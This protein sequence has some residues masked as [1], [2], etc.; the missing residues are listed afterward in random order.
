MLVADDDEVTPTNQPRL[1]REARARLRGDL[2]TAEP[3]SIAE[4]MG[5]GQEP[6][7]PERKMGGIAAYNLAHD[8]QDWLEWR[9]TGIGASEVAMLYGWGF[10]NQSP[11]QL[12]LQKVGLIAPGDELDNERFEFGRRAE[13]MIARWFEDETGLYVF[14]EQERRVHD[15]YSWCIATIDG[16]VFEGPSRDGI[17]PL[18]GLEIKTTSSFDWKPDEPIPIRYAAQGQWQM[19]VCGWER[20]WFAVLHGT[21]FRVYVLE[22]DEDDIT[23]LFE[24]AGRF[25][26]DHV[27]A[28]VPPDLDESPATSRAL[29]QAYRGD[30]DRTTADLSELQRSLT[31]LREAKAEIAKWKG[32]AYLHENEIKAALGD[33][34][35][36]DFGKGP[37]VTWSRFNRRSVDTALL[38]QRFPEIYEIVAKSTP[39]STFRVS[40]EKGEED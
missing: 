38:K 10:A 26:H 7:P 34:T 30:R 12:W 2:P 17:E 18:G 6:P 23:D 15:H 27:L 22:R 14:H 13:P 35:Y 5:Y 40:G 20:L 4:A 39:S 9:R 19:F 21:A 1:N 25:W 3:G 36:G 24:R 8:R 33:A 29:G 31:D 32:R 37:E 16:E 28:V 11:Y